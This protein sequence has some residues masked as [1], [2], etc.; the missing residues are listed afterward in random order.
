MPKITVLLVLMCYMHCVVST[1][2][3]ALCY[4]HS[5]I[6]TVLLSLCYRHCDSAFSNLVQ[7]KGIYAVLA[8]I[9]LYR[10]I[11]S[12][13]AIFSAEIFICAILYAFSISDIDIGQQYYTK[14]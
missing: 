7:F 5:V 8:R 6:S 3:L 4:K 12:F 2:L 1:V 9:T 13:C 14:K 10:K 11:R